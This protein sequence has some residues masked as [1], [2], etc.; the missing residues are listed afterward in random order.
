MQ[1][2]LQALR[3]FLRCYQLSSLKINKNTGY[4]SFWSK[5]RMVLRPSFFASY[6]AMSACL[7]SSPG[8]VAMLGY[9]KRFRK[10]RRTRE[11]IAELRE[12]DV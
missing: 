1:C 6:I 11:W 3:F 4:A 10:V 8:A 7:T 9:A 5:N 12:K 2:S